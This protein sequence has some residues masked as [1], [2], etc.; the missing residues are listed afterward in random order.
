MNDLNF[1]EI[2][3]KIGILVINKINTFK[4]NDLVNIFFHELVKYTTSYHFA[5]TTFLQNIKKPF[6]PFVDQDYINN[7]E[8]FVYNKRNMSLSLKFSEKFLVFF[9]AY[10]G[11]K[12]ISIRESGL[13][14]FRELLRLV[15]KRY[16]IVF[17]SNHSIFLECYEQSLIELKEL[18]YDLANIISVV[19]NVDE[20]VLNFV[21]FVEIHITR[22]RE[23]PEADLLI[24]GSNLILEN[25][26]SSYHFMS[27]NKS[28]VSLGHGDV[29]IFMYDEPFVY[30]GEISLCTDYI[31]Y[32]KADAKSSSRFDYLQGDIKP[33]IHYRSGQTIIS[34][35]K[36]A[37]LK[38]KTKFNKTL[39][40]LYVPTAFSGYER[41][42]PFRDYNDEIYQNF[43]KM[44]AN[45]DLRISYKIH[46]STGGKDTKGFFDYING[47]LK[48]LKTLKKFDFFII[49][50][51]STA[52]TVLQA[53]DK[54]ILYFDIG[55]RNLN[56]NVKS[57]LKERMHYKKINLDGNISE[58]LIDFIN[59]L[60]GKE[61]NSKAD[62][63]NLY[64]KS[65]HEETLD[66][67]ISRIFNS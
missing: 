43:Q 27:L 10:S 23:Y 29:S 64:V 8:H 36:K 38:S 51:I 21:S 44:I 30:Y 66:K 45:L 26:I 53:T 3:N 33:R 32:G 58:E 28:V 2:R 37:S 59:D 22:S 46:P 5:S 16:K 52:S 67:I 12:T 60:D 57:L 7:I 15:L 18:L 9:S 17:L 34:I 62:F 19:N 48:N 24:V 47:N 49:D 41:Y 61:M 1:E 54:H 56:D 20:F 4:K 42:S 31:T 39:K 55:L 50:Y 63:L 11:N 65:E 35:W 25:R 40:G 13:L 14:T 6:F